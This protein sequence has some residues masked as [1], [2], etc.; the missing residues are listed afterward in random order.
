MEST[1]HVCKRVVITK[2]KVKDS[3]QEDVKRNKVQILLALDKADGSAPLGYIA[4]KSGI[5]D[6]LELLQ[7]LEKDGFVCRLSPSYCGPSLL[8]IFELT[9]KSKTIIR[10]ATETRLEQLIDT[11]I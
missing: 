1:L 5:E 10:Q 6:P 4:E 8:P 11:R 7:R 3:L 2:V 9:S